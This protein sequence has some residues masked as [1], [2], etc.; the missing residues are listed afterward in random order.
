MC[1]H[2]HITSRLLRCKLASAN[3]NAEQISYQTNTR[4]CGVALLDINCHK[5]QKQQQQRR[6]A[7]EKIISGMGLF[8]KKLICTNSF[9]E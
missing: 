4:A 7:K 8:F 5:Q 3:V 6:S 9:S 2:A 1:V